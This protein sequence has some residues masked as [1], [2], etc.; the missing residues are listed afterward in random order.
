V[1]EAF[2]ANANAYSAG[3]HPWP[4]LQTLFLMAFGLSHRFNALLV[5]FL[6]PPSLLKPEDGLG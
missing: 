3:A 2:N 6:D 1:A 5:Q 4:G